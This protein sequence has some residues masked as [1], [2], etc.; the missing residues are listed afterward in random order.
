MA[1]D[2]YFLATSM[3]FGSN[4]SASSLEPFRRAIQSLIPIYLM[5]MD[6]VEKHK[7]LL[8][9]LVWEDGDT[10]IGVLVQAVRCPFNPGIP[11]QHGPLEAYIYVDDILASA[12]EKKNILRLLAAIIKAI[13]TVCGRSMTKVRQCLLSLNK[14]EEFVVGLVQTALGLAMNT[15]KLTIGIREM[16]QITLIL[17]FCQLVDLTNLRIYPKTSQKMHS[18]TSLIT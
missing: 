10:L 14:W 2:V 18:L 11:D 7:H 16:C 4:T 15:S 1:E 12:V 5:R 13:F 8:D 3:V 9:M 6:L 17:L